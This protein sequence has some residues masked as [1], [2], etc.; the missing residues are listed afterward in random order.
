MSALLMLAGVSAVVLADESVVN[1]KHD[2]SARGPG[3]IRAVHEDEVCIF[4]HT[5]HNAAPQTP[6]WN[7]ANPQTFYRIYESSTTDAR[8]D[9][10][11]GPSKMCLACH[12]GSMALGNVLTRPDTHPIVMTARTIPPGYADLSIDLSDDHPIGFRYDRALSNLDPQ[13]RA[14]EVVSVRLPLGA[15]RELQCTTCHDPHNNQLGDFLRITDEMSAMCVACHDMDGWALAS[16]ATSGKRTPGRIVDPGERL[17]YANV[18]D[19][20]CMTCHKIHSAPYPERLLR[21]E[22]EEENCLNCHSGTIA[23]F[24]IAADIGK[25]AAHEVERRTD[26]HDPAENPFTMRRH[27]ECVDCHNPHAVRHNPIGTVRGTFG[28]TVKGPNLNVSGM[29]ISGGYRDDA[30]FLYEICFKCHGD[31]TGRPRLNTS[32]QV[33]QTNTRLEFQVG[34][35]SFHPVAGP[36]RSPDSRSLIPPLRPGSIITCTDCHNSD[37]ARSMGGSGAN[38]PHGSRFESLL[39][40]NYETDDFTAESAQAYALCYGCHDRERILGNESFPSH[41]RHVVDIQAPCNVC[42]DPHGIYRGQGNSTNHSN[43][44]NFDLSV[45]MPAD[46]PEGRRIVYEDTGTLSG[47]CTLTCHGFTHIGF[48]YVNVGGGGAARMRSY[49]PGANR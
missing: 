39:V 1:S 44:I 5:P 28:Q 30:V 33:T 2:L 17:K 36:R 25:R 4:C 14:P 8:I 23:D 19:N 9:Q 16:H 22:R 20:G 49:S 34:N 13:I 3:P 10:P 38:G 41:R 29:A 12:D 7:R 37:N 46:T 35:P 40:R 31:S 21:F 27:V 11:T 26:V 24:N 18:R 48:P 6:L 32:R 45:V 43:L 47:S 42:H 15:H